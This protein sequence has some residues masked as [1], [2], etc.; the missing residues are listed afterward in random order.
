MGFGYLYE[1]EIMCLAMVSSCSS[2]TLPDSGGLNDY[3]VVLY[4]YMG[5]DQHEK[6]VSTFDIFI[7]R[8]II[9]VD[10][11]LHNKFCYLILHN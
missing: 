3:P 10:C 5:E 8:D 11:V 6:A 9:C 4:S 2:A 1:D 7:V